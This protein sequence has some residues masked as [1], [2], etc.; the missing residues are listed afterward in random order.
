MTKISLTDSFTTNKLHLLITIQ[1][2]CCLNY[3]I[4]KFKHFMNA[5]DTQKYTLFIPQ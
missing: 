1:C 3:K 4:S 2:L 5:F